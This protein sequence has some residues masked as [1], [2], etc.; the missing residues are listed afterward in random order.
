MF[1]LLIRQARVVDPSGI[2]ARDVAIKDGIISALLPPAAPADARRVLDRPG[3]LLMPGLVD[4]H[5]HLREP[6]L[7][8]KEDFDSGTQAAAVGGVTTVLVMPTDDP[9]TVTPRQLQ[10]KMAQASGR[11]H[12]DAAFQVAVERPPGD[13][14]TLK[15]LGAVS[16][17]VFTADAP[18]SFRH[19]NLHDLL[20]ALRAIA[21]T[22]GL[23]GLSPGDQ[24]LLSAADL[25]SARDIADFL[26]MRPPAAEASGIAMAVAAAAGT[27][28]I[29]HIRQISSALGVETFRRM[30]G[31]AY[32]SIE[33][34]PQCLLFTQADY[35][36]LGAVLKA[37][38]PLR[39]AEDVAALRQA[40]RDGTIDMIVSDHAPHTAAEK[41][42]TYDRFADIPGG[43]P[44][45]QTLLA[46][47]LHLVALGEIGLSD[48]VRLCSFA[49]AKRF[50]LSER[51]GAIAVGRDADILVIDPE[52]DTRISASGLY[53]K[54]KHTPFEGIVIPYRLERV[55]LRGVDISAN[56]LPQARHSGRILTRFNRFS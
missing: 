45:V 3:C 39:E 29:V 46:T 26:A 38:P 56:G 31:M 50:G 47:M 13:V 8:H 1:D 41:L 28:A 5:V 4:A 19:E 6:G 34:T 23:I 24:S 27:Q 53:S 20:A 44:G 21:R 18:Q 40:L 7:T 30:K 37:S 42:A 43:F 12:V 10:E 35:R 2:A 54:T 36:K 14:A 55:L 51:K 33:T 16:F 25:P 17:E 11:L 32:I 22:G 49:P 48:V 9:W 52:A 15:S